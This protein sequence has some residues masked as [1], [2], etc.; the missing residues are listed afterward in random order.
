MKL[1]V[2]GGPKITT[3]LPNKKEHMTNLFCSLHSTHQATTESYYTTIIN[4]LTASG[5]FTHVLLTHA[6]ARSLARYAWDA[7]AAQSVPVAVEAGVVASE[8][9]DAVDAVAEDAEAEEDA[10]EQHDHQ[11]H[12]QAATHPLFGELELAHG[13]AT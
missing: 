4:Y 8:V 9:L 6:P 5:R 2:R 10:D 11:D 12:Q 7:A 1:S 3:I 13:R